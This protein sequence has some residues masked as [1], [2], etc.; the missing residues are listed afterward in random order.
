VASGDGLGDGA[1]GPMCFVIPSETFCN[2]L[3]MMR[4]TIPFP[5]QPRSCFDGSLFG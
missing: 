1:E 3:N 5:D 2:N 4:S